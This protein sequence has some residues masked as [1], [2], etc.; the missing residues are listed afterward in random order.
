MSEGVKIVFGALTPPKG[1][2]YVVF[3][4][5]DLKV[6]PAVAALIGD[7]EGLIREAAK[8][9]HFRGAQRTALDILAPAGIAAARLLV[10]GVAPGKDGAPS[11]SRRLAGLRSGKLS[12]A[13]KA[14]VA[15]EAPAGTW[16]SAAAADFALGMR[17]RG[18]RFDKYKTRKAELDDEWVEQQS[19]V[20][21]VGDLPAARATAIERFATAEG[22]ELARDLV[23]EPPNVLFP[24]EFA[25]RAEGLRK[26]GVASKFSTKRRC[27][28]TEWAPCSP[29]G[30]GRSV[31]AASS[32]CGGTA[33][34]AR[35]PSRSPSSARACASTAAAFRSSPPPIW[36]I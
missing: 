22:V 13:K 21:G 8:A 34:R 26:L 36:R 7:A 6:A 35:S 33:P 12:G 9:A 30:R 28:S 23:N 11:I 5:A 31:T 24:E 16:D 4:G 19:I 29:S 20:L 27:E 3:V 32:S 18:Y 10:I 25:K 1:G 2:A 14:D 17:L 15:F